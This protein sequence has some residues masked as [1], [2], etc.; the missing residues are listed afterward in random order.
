MEDEAG[1]WKAA[2]QKDKFSQQVASANA[3]AAAILRR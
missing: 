1:G 2:P 3:F